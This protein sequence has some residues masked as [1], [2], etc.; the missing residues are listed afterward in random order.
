MDS[1]W[2]GPA[3]VL[4]SEAADPKGTVLLMHGQ[5]ADA[6]ANAKE[7]ALL[8]GAGWNAVGID[9]P[10]HGRRFDTARDERWAQDE[11]AAL[12]AHVEQ[13]GAELPDIVD[14]AE[15]RGLV[16]PYA[17]AGISLGA[18]SL[19][20]GLGT[21]ERLCTGLPILGSPVMPGEPAPA[22]SQWKGCRVLAQN[23]EHD[24]VVPIG[25]TEA[26][27]SALGGTLHVIAGSPHRV[28]ELE[29][30][31]LWGRALSWL[32]QTNR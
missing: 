17:L 3:P 13:A 28:P 20:R 19:W 10:E 1:D 7:L 14:G 16:G 5:G 18:F 23:A 22:P 27:V 4:I 15:A 25:P 21:D 9:A 2:F 8:A 6:L 11:P 24:Q 29:W 31:A 32:D 30:W 12:A 26:V